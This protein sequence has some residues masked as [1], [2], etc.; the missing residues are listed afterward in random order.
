VPGQSVTA[1]PTANAAPVTMPNVVGMTQAQA[2]RVL[3]QAGFLVNVVVQSAS[4]S[5]R[6]TGGTV[7]EEWPYAGA[8]APR[9][10]KITIY[11]QP[12]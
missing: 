4:G 10:A 8:S 2:V 7:W 12:S 5:Q 1:V 3:R 9:G 6:V 11:V